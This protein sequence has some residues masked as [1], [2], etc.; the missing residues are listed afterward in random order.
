MVFGTS[1]GEVYFQKLALNLAWDDH[2]RKKPT[3]HSSGGA[4]EYRLIKLREKLQRTLLC[5]LH[6]LL[7]F[8]PGH[9]AGLNFP[10]TPRV[11]VTI[12]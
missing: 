9:V 11:L 7:F 3:L 4:R 12:Q 5:V 6:N 8:P 2:P 1:D 10:V